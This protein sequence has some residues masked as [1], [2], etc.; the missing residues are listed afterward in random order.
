MA[1]F[2]CA[3]HQ[4]TWGGDR[5]LEA[6]DDIRDF[7]YSGVETFAT[8]VDTYAGREDAFAALLAARG[9]KLA[10][11]YGGGPLSEAG[12]TGE[13]IARNLRIGQFLQRLGSRQ[14]VLGTGRRPAGGPTAEHFL[15]LAKACDEI[16]QGCAALGVVA[17]IHPHFNNPVQFSAE[18]DRIFDLVDTRVVKLAFDPAHIAKVHEDPL[19]VAERYRD[20]LVYVH[21]KDYVPALDTDV[22]GGAA[23]EDAPR[24]AFFGELGTGTVDT[25]GLIDILRRANYDGWVT[26]ELDRS[27]TSP[28]QSLDVNT[29]YLRETLGFNV[30]GVSR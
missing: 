27:Q 5:L 3:C 11:L 18:V 25:K 12:Q 23:R 8:V 10:A 16:G 1:A 24:L 6:L 29:R 22:P 13:L 7:G 26:V 28:R 9:L 14:L 21:L 20:I 30:S 15:T 19:R 4:I 17:G 2:R